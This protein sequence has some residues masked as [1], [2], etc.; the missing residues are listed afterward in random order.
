MI[1]HINCQQ[2]LYFYLTL[3]LDC[4]KHYLFSASLKNTNEHKV[5]L[6]KLILYKD[7]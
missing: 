3:F 4:R 2:F 6:F 5:S 7:N 1:C